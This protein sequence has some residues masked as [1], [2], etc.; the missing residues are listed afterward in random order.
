MIKDVICN[1]LSASLFHRLYYAFDDLQSYSV[2]ELERS[3]LFADAQPY[4]P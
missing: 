2:S 1:L 3:V 4:F